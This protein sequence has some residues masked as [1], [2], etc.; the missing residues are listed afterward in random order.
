MPAM[1]SPPRINY[2]PSKLSPPPHATA[3]GASILFILD[4]GAN[5]STASR[6]IMEHLA[7]NP[8]D[9]VAMVVLV[10]TESEREKA[11]LN[12]TTWLERVHQSLH[13]SAKFVI[14]I[15]V[16]PEINQFKFRVRSLISEISP[17]LVVLGHAEHGRLDSVSAVCMKDAG[18]RVVVEQF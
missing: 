15:L 13:P 16:E 14:H 7:E 8:D 4:E 10:R 6:C 9:H 1:V 11:L 12:T 5:A 17:E 2:S 3:A 18:C